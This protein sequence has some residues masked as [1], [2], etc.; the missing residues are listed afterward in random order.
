MFKYLLLINN[1]HRVEEDDDGRCFDDD[2]VQ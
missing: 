2:H 1:D